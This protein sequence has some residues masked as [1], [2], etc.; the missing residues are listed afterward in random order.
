MSGKLNQNTT[1]IKPEYIYVA[2]SW[3]NNLQPAII[4]FLNAAGIPNY[5]FKGT[6]QSDEEF[7]GFSWD[8]IETYKGNGGPNFQGKH[9][10]FTQDFLIGLNHPRAQ[11]GFM[12][13]WNAMQKADTFILVLPCGKSAHLELGWAIGAGKRTIILAEETIERE[14]MYLMADHLVTSTFELLNLLGVQDK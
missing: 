13:D 8:Q 3:K 11:E 10:A 7:I 14:L 6:F 9:D 1:P 2:S 5:D 12:A 4:A